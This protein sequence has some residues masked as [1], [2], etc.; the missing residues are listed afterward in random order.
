MLNGLSDLYM[1]LSLAFR[2]PNDPGR[3]AAMRAYLVGDLAAAAQEA[4]VEFAAADLTA[5]AE[6]LA[7][8]PDDL[9]LLQIYSALFL[10]PPRLA[11]LS[12]GIYLDGGILGRSVDGMRD[13]YRRHGVGY[14]GT[15]GDLPD[16]LAV[17]LEFMALLYGR[18]AVAA[19]NDSGGAAQTKLIAE[20]EFFRD[21]YILPWLP[22]LISKIAAADIA[23]V[24][25][26]NPYLALVRL[27]LTLAAAGRTPKPARV[28]PE[29]VVTT[30]ATKDF[31]IC[32]VC[33]ASFA[34]STELRNMHKILHKKGIDGDFLNACPDCRTT[35]MGAVTLIPPE[36][37]R[38]ARMDKD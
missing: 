2:T 10:T 37:R 38:H 16:H 35:E 8:I 15:D 24:A 17:Q 32:R 9:T 23:A 34:L 11:S 7:A 20:A 3:V 18:A 19:D 29:R 5:L 36:L 25:S 21:V 1:M 27:A 28:Q 4:A 22:V 30:T 13:A 31:Q 12:A 6:A 14:A 26:V 33:G